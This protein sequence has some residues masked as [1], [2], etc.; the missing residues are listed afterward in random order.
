MH[1]KRE[2][3]LIILYV[4]YMWLKDRISTMVKSIF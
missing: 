2:M 4:D 3:F 1:N